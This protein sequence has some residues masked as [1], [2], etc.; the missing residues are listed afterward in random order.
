MPTN[1]YDVIVI[2]DDFAGLVAA[3]LCARRGLRVL[4][5]S[6][7]TASPQVYQLGP[8]R[9]PVEP[10]PLPGLGSP[11]IRRVLEELSFDHPLKRRLLPAPVSFQLVMPGA[12][13]NVSS[14]DAALR[15][16]VD[17]ELS[18]EAAAAAAA[19]CDQAAYLGQQLDPILGQ[20]ISLPPVGFWEKRE[21]ARGAAR[22][23]EESA[24][25]FAELESDP[26]LR[27]LV[28]L[29]SIFGGRTDPLSLTHEARARALHSW[30]LGAPRLRGD[31]ETLYEMFDEKLANHSGEHR[32]AEVAGLTYSWGKV[33][34]VRLGNGE[35]LGAGHVIAAMP[36]DQLVALTEGKPEKRLAQYDEEILA[37]GYRYT[38]N[39]VLAEV[40]IPEGMAPTVLVVGDPAEPL[41]GDNAF[42]IFVGEPDDEARVVVSLQAIC[43][44]PADAD[45]H[46]QALEQA[47]AALRKNLLER[48]AQVMPFYTGH[49][50]AAHSPHQAAPAVGAVGDCSLERPVPAQP[51]WN[52]GLE[53]VLGVSAVP[54]SVGIKNLTVASAQVLPGLGLEGEFVAGWCAARIAGGTAGK[55][56]DYLKNEVL[57]GSSAR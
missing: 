34:G 54:Y 48:L 38:L 1:S 12:R 26:Q 42:A 35:E 55:K 43:R 25:W 39:L 50:L 32:A 29:P 40:A 31:R 3:T 53:A 11:A 19:A 47:F 21:V 14:D 57:A 44:A 56:R 5:L 36:V 18:E 49:V 7:E 46:D 37:A 4:R 9:L 45:D 23:A 41:I 33:N 15:R 24:A 52:S 28:E 2:G 10:L 27:A 22:L 17:R 30:R 16:E 20:E 51:V 13:I 8:H 6:E